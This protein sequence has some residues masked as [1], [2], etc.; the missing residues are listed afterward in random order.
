MPPELPLGVRISHLAEHRDFRG[1]FTEVFR[2]EWETG[3]APVQWNFVRSAAGVLRGVHVHHRHSDYLVV[4]EG[5]VTL[6]LR[7]LR[8]GSPTR[9][10]AAL[11]SLEGARLSAVTIPRGVAHGF[12][13]HGPSLH[14]YAV[15]HTWDPG[16]ELGCH[17]KDPELGLDWPVAEAIL[18]SRDAGLPPLRVLLDS[19]EP[20][21]PFAGDPPPPSP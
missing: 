21:Q 11:V 13:F 16:D 14:L 6:G 8:R 19:L 18:S 3:I 7:D 10:L 5:R 1:S 4:L 9:D 17:W 15:S 2:T 12:L 20:H